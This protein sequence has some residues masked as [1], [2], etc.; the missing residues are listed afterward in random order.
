[1]KISALKNMYPAQVKTV[2]YNHCEVPSVYTDAV[3]EYDVLRHHIGVIDGIGFAVLKVQGDEAAEFLDS[4]VT[5]DICFLNPGKVSECLFLNEEAEPLGLTYIINNEDSFVVLVPPENAE[6]V[7]K[8]IQDKLVDGV[9]VTDMTQTHSLVFLEGEK[10]WK[11]IRELFNFA[12]ETLPLRDMTHIDYEGEKILLTR[13]GRSG[14]Y[15]YA[16]LAT[17]ATVVKYVEACMSKFSD[18]GVEFCGTDALETCMLEISQPLISPDTAKEGNLFEFAQQWFV[19]YEKEDFCGHEKLVELFEGEK[20]RLSVGFR[21]CSAK[22]IP[23]GATVSLYGEE[24]GK[25]VRAKYD[26]SFD[27]V[28]GIAMLRIDIAVSGIELTVVADGEE[29]TIETLSSPFVRPLSWDSQ[30]D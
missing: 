21:C 27:G 4:L 12:V 19:Q 14:E 7:T 29:H 24:V 16:V 23:D 18:L 15:G 2:E 17:D 5:K 9:T 25:V 10:S 22:T 28:L 13:I 11:I 1:M 30:I 20:E 26:P 8:W 3:H 6:T